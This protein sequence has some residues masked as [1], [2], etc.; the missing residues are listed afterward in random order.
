MAARSDYGA[1][2]SAAAAAFLAGA[3]SVF[4][5]RW[6]HAPATAMATCAILALLPGVQLYQGLIEA[7][8]S[9]PHC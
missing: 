8:G 6:L 2:W 4:Y 1:V 5:A 9:S 7:T 3:V